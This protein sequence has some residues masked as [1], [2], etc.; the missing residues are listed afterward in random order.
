MA[1][2]IPISLLILPACF[3]GLGVIITIAATWVVAIRLGR[4]QGLHEGRKSGYL[5]GRRSEQEAA[6]RE[7]GAQ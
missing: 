2:N 6:R 4:R 3:I 5:D 1:T 7:G